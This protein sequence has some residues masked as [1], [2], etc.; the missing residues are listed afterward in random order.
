MP[1]TR[2]IGQMLKTETLCV[3]QTTRIFYALNPFLET[4]CESLAPVLLDTDPACYVLP[5]A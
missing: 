4:G 1:K 5:S 2:N 3:R